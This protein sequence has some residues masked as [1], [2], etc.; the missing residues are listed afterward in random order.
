MNPSG[1]NSFDE[2]FMKATFT[3][4]NAAPQFESSNSGPWNKYEDRIRQYAKCPCGN[5]IRGGTLYLLTGTSDYGL[6]PGGGGIP[7][8]DTTIAL[9]YTRLMFPAGVKLVTPR[10]VWTAGC[11]VWNEPGK[12]IGSYWQSAKAESFAVMS[13]NQD[14]PA[15]LHQTEMS[16]AELEDLLT[17]PGTPKVN[18]FPGSQQCRNPRNP[19]F[20]L[21]I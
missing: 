14:N 5:D 7:V 3:L 10:A 20:R 8:Q 18:L 13:N 17:E 19:D 4:T 1:I 9:P 11:C 6:K 2:N 12:I 16:V 15:L 21:P